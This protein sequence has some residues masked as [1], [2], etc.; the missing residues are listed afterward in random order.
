M[1]TTKYLLLCLVLL[2]LVSLNSCKN[3][4][5][6]TPTTDNGDSSNVHT[7]S[8]S[9]DSVITEQS[10]TQDGLVLYTCSCGETKL[11]RKNALGHTFTEWQEISPATCSSA[12]SEKRTC[13]TCSETENRSTN[14]L[15][16]N[17]ASTE[18]TVNGVLTTTYLCNMCSDSFS[19]ATTL[20]DGFEGMSARRISNCASDFSFYLICGEDEEYI[21]ENLRIFDAYYEGSEYEN[22]KDVVC[23]YSLAE[24]EKNIWLVTPERNYVPGNTYKAVRSGDVVFRDYGIY[25]LTFSI[26]K[27]KTEVID[28]NDNLI[29]I[30]NLENKNPGYYPYTIEYSENSDIHWLTLKKIDG[31]KIG[32]VVCV[33]S[34]TNIDEVF[35]NYNAEN[36]FGKIS[37]IIYVQSEDHYLISLVTPEMSEIF[38]EIDIYTSKMQQAGEIETNDDSTVDSVVEVLMNDEDFINFAAASYVTTLEYVE[39]RGLATP[40]ASFREFLESIKIDKEKGYGPEINNNGELV[41]KIVINGS[42]SI[43]VTTMVDERNLGNI[44][45][46]FEAHVTLDYLRFV[47]GCSE[48][49]LANSE[50]IDISKLK[51][52]VEQSVTVGFEFNVEMSIEY[53]MDSKPYVCNLKTLTYHY[54]GCKHVSSIK[55]ENMVWHTAE[56]I[57]AD[58]ISGEINKDHECKSCKPFSA[59]LSDSYVLNHK[60][61]VIHLPNCSRLP[62]DIN[63][64]LTISTGQYGNFLASGYSPCGTCKPQ[65]RLN[66]SFS[67]SLLQKIKSQDFGKSTEEIKEIAEEIRNS[68]TDRNIPIAVVPAVVGP[69]ALNFEVNIYLDFK[70]EASFKYEYEVNFTSEFGFE[71]TAKGIESYSDYKTNVNINRITAMGKMRLDLG[72]DGSIRAGFKG[73]EKKLYIKMGIKAGPYAKI[74]GALQYDFVNTSN[75]YMAAYLEVGIHMDVYG[76]IRI[77]IILTNPKHIDFWEKDIPKYTAGYS[78]LVYDYVYYPEEIVFDETV[79]PLVQDEITKVKMYDLTKM[80]E[81][82][83]NITPV[84]APGRYE[85]IFTLERGENCYI[86][87]GYLYVNEGVSSFT[88]QLTMSVVGK[89]KNMLITLPIRTIQIV[90]TAPISHDE[91][92]SKEVCHIVYGENCIYYVYRCTHCDDWI[93][94]YVDYPDSVTTSVTM[95]DLI[96]ANGWDTSTRGQSF[97]IDDVVTVQINGGKY[98]GAA[99]NGDQVRLYATDSPAGSITISAKEGYE[100][101]SVKISTAEVDYDV[102]YLCVDGTGDDISNIETYVFGSSIALHSVQ[103]GD[104]GRHVKVTAIKVVYKST[105]DEGNADTPSNLE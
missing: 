42:V 20:V 13:E 105:G 70:L 30:Q 65:S 63:S 21:R 94:G 81:L 91:K 76:E 8:W 32:D 69:F 90:Y 37:T 97:N 35:G 68:D 104:N 57:M 59:L 83:D 72:F 56:D 84:G 71:K 7:C 34:A 77:P 27:E 44:V 74:H 58:V 6:K 11:E 48:D 16:H 86:E 36:T 54:A 46:S 1:K 3:N 2:V 17:Y 78:L 103:N 45:I 75:S 38:D 102:A 62:S 89:S 47:A 50:N 67:E 61:K 87:N 95:A 99:Y 93:V 80:N 10:C 28:V 82:T 18:E 4:K 60:T 53:S 40:V 66:N 49:E 23:N 12:G 43:P 101:V 79:F 100:L 24:T 41:A 64:T 85:V 33:G 55:P 52:G 14:K 15:T 5:D 51:L 31:L 9:M 22:H 26:F 73:L 29:F 98:S 39:T 92:P 19:V 25:D 96:S 88:D